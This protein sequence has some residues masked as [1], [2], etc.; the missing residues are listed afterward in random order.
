MKV[1]KE[2][3]IKNIAERTGG[4]IYLGVVGAVRTGKSTFIKKVVENLI[5]PN[6]EDEFERKRA[7]DEIPQSSG[8]KT[9]MTIEPKFVPNNIAKINIDNLECNMRLVDCV[10]YVIESAKGYEDENGP[11]MVKTPWYNEEIP[12][13]EA[14][15]IGTEKVIKDHST[16][17][18]IV[19]TDGS[20][21]DFERRDYIEAEEKVVGELTEINKPFIMILNS[22]HPT[23]PETTHLAEEMRANYGIPVIPMD[24]MSM[25]E[26]DT[27]DILREAL[28]EFPVLEVKVDM[29]EWI[30]ILNHNHYIKKAY[31]EKIKESVIEVEK[32]RDVDTITS[33]FND[34]EYIKKA[35][36]SKVDPST[37]TVTV[38]LDA[39]D[40]LFN[41]ALN[42]MIGIDVSSKASLMAMFQDY[43]ESK[44]EYDQVKTALKMVKTTGYGV[45]N[46]TL[47]DMKLDTPEITKQGSRYGIKLKATAPS[48]HMIR[49]D[50]ESTFEP[51]IGS[52][53]QSKE[54]INYL[55]KDSEK[56]PN[57]I[58]S[59]EIFGRSLDVIVQEGIQSKIAMMPEN[60]RYKLQQTMSKVVN[61]GSGNLIAIVI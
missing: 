34:C 22:T 2:E 57:N 43:K 9:I 15:E 18:I 31:I 48:I 39:P 37:G 23:N 7:L 46:P 1:N 45:A 11:R 40:D 25:N 30:G 21:G 55:M 53:M 61:K 6:I 5:I 50:V 38:T 13:V 4:D 3:I 47:N 35:Y 19:T 29:P 41:T 58:W 8:G 59:S 24:V 27:Y 20:I 36:M 10:G 26:K 60:V 51:I 33:H 54:L 14:A 32:L 17:G 49:V 16:I 12:F 56:D 44:M 42:E 52:E 28:Y